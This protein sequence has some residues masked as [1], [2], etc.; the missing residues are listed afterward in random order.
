MTIT[1][2]PKYG[3]ILYIYTVFRVMENGKKMRTGGWFDRREKKEEEPMGVR[4]TLSED[5]NLGTQYCAMN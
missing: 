1:I 5:G 2:N 4:L 3:L